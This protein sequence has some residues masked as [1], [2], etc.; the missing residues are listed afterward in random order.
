MKHLLFNKLGCIILVFSLI[1]PSACQKKQVTQI[2]QTPPTPT[3]HEKVIVKPEEN[4]KIPTDQENTFDVW[5]VLSEEK[6]SIVK[7]CG[8]LV[9]N[10]M[11][12]MVANITQ[13]QYDLL[14][15]KNIKV[16][17][18]WEWVTI[19]VKDG[20]SDFDNQSRF[21]PDAY[22]DL[23]EQES[24]SK[25]TFTK[26]RIYRDLNQDGIPEIFFDLHGG[27]GGENYLIYQ[28]TKEGYKEMGSYFYLAMQVLP[29]KHNDFCDIMTYQHINNKVALLRIMEFNG[30][31]YLTSKWLEGF[32]QDA[33]EEKIFQPDFQNVKEE[34]FDPKWSPNDDDKYRR[35][36]ADLEKSMFDVRIEINDGLAEGDDEQEKSTVINS[37]LQ[38]IRDWLC[39]ILGRAT[40]VQFDSL[41]KKNIK[42]FKKWEWE[43]VKQEKKEN[44]KVEPKKF[45][46]DPYKMNPAGLLRKYKDINQD[47][48]PELF[49]S[50]T[51][52]SSSGGHF[53]VY[54]ITKEGYLDLDLQILR[55]HQF[56]STSHNG[57]LD[58]IEYSPYYA[59][60]GK[61]LQ[62][63]FD[64][65]F[66]WVVKK[67][68]VA[69]WELVHNKT[70]NPDPDLKQDFHPFIRDENDNIKL[71]WSPKDDDKYRRMIK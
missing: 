38:I 33:I 45:V 48:I 70:I 66:Y 9:N 24:I 23:L 71:I 49:L 63:E 16:Y 42:I 37:G 50:N 41:K 25:F 65:N 19:E 47:G 30:S 5:F 51:Y 60:C 18:K 55:K 54:Q 26:S 22:K 62:F 17:K 44:V 69:Y 52:S 64:G 13:E 32:I 27:I 2:P 20:K 29:T 53:E 28:I 4:I 31:E 15:Q 8:V 14:K 43:V 46:K 3:A 10:D 12:L 68:S 67:I 7:E 61:I 39:F 56:L 1:F 36:L 40:Q 57:F 34:D 59:E 21:V 58:F 35:M 6:E 11:G